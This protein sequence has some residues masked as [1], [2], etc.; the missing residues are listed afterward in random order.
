MLDDMAA[1]DAIE[2]FLLVREEAENVIL[3]DGM[4][5]SRAAC[6]QGFLCPIHS[7]SG[8]SFLCEKVK[9]DAS[10]AT[11]IKNM[12]ARPEIG[13]KTTPYTSHQLLGATKGV[14]TL[15][16]AFELVSINDFLHKT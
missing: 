2:S 10:A 11:E 4:K 8:N 7:R 14:E 16:R 5:P 1:E 12:F 13:E 6:V 3:K 15:T 9:K